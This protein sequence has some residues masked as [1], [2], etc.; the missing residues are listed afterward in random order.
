[1]RAH[2][3]RERFAR[4]LGACIAI[5]LTAI[6]LRLLCGAMGYGWPERL[7]LGIRVHRA[8]LAC[9]V[10]AALATSGVILQSLLR[11][12]LA[13]PY[14][15]G[16][17]TGAG[18]GILAQLYL[19]RLQLI[20]HAPDH[21]G[22]LVGALASLGVVFVAGRRNGVLDPLGL[23]LV[24]VVLATIN[25]ALIT[26]LQYLSSQT[27]RE[28]LAYWMMGYLNES[29]P[30]TTVAVAAAIIVSG[31]AITACFHRAMDLAAL[32][33]AESV[34]LGLALPR[35]R[36]ILFL[37]AGA[38]T[39]AAVVL[40]GPIAFVGFI[41]PHLVRLWAGPLHARVLPASILVGASIILAGDSL[42]TIIHMH[43]GIGTPPIGVF[44]A[45]LVGPLFLWMLR[46]QLGR[47][48]E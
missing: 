19:V 25:G 41:A 10:G 34:S 2:G 38:L 37:V 3:D 12:P 27:L 1:M 20:G 24:G 13:E 26:L 8:M 45:V 21:V 35:C 4:I 36:T 47:G 32:S 6:L 23:L 7:V 33:D 40:A 46:P 18:L 17:S 44:T 29:L 22:A 9:L 39:A 48:M 5:L 28:N 11:N 31:I 30:R 15:L 14:I 42:A 43:T 16:V